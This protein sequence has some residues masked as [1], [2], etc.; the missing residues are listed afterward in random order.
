MISIH[1]FT[2]NPFQENTYLL[3]D[4]T[5]QCVIIDPGCSNDAERKQLT[6]FITANS[7][8]PVK[9]VNTHCHIDHILGNKFISTTY[10]LELEANENDLKTLAAGRVSADIFGIEYEESPL[11][12]L[13]LNEGDTVLFGDSKLEIVFT[14]G[15]S[16]GSICF[17]NAENKFVIG[18]DVLFYQSIG[19]TDLPGGNHQQLLESIRTKLF[20]LP[21]DYT[22]Y[23]G[24]GPSTTIGFEQKNNPFLA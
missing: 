2:F 1:A 11:P 4:A 5:K 7:L 23:P 10:G 19:R 15:H 13:F 6:D 12:K 14:P 18:G 8:T 21:A 3:F 17:I 20:V 24:H 9:L 16:A 22:V